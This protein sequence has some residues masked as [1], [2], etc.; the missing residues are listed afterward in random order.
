MTGPR[1]KRTPPKRY[2]RIDVTHR[3]D[4]ER[5][6]ISGYPILDDIVAEDTPLNHRSW[7][8]G[9]CGGRF[10]DDVYKCPNCG[11]NREQP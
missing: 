9:Y 2:E 10:A 11:A 5:A 3:G 8:C 4:R 7:S 6:F 1:P